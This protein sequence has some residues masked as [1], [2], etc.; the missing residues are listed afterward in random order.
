MECGNSRQKTMVSLRGCLV[1]ERG[2][3]VMVLFCLMEINQLI[4]GK[5]RDV[6]LRLGANQTTAI[7]E[8]V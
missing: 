5:I 8:M 2:M 4:Y 3:G 6:A 7:A 1:P